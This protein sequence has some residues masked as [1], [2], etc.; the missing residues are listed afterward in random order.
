[1]IEKTEFYEHPDLLA[2]TGSH[3]YGVAKPS[4]D[5]DYRGFVCEP[6]DFVLGFENFEQKEYSDCD[7]IV[8]GLKKFFKILQQGNTQAVE[9]L[10]ANKYEIKTEIG[11]M[12]IKNRDIFISK[13]YCRTVRG[14][15][16][17]EMR[18]ARA[19]NLVMKYDDDDT[20]KIFSRLFGK[21][22]LSR[23]EI[24]EI[25]NII[26]EEREGDPRREEPSTRKLGER[27]K[28][29]VEKHGYSVKNAYHA[30]RLLDQGIELMN[31]HILTF[32]RR[33]VEELKAIRNGDFSLEDIEKRFNELNI[34]LKKA[35]ETS[36]LPEKPNYHSIVDLYKTIF[37]MKNI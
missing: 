4:S 6:L 13:S 25:L 3:L 35:Q 1:M 17:S 19:V 27:R 8:Y 9:V 32:P 22:N 28:E 36:T 7:K 37:Y 23:L 2:I 16:L 21:Y 26:F 14:F 24:N 33:N 34:E 30:I 29:D 5:T 10:F 11:D 15:A 18:K 31:N 20:E 12:V